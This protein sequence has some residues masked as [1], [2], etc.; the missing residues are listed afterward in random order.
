MGAWQS[1]DGAKAEQ[2]LPLLSAPGMALKTPKMLLH[3]AFQALPH[4]GELYTGVVQDPHGASQA[5]S[6]RATITLPSLLDAPAPLGAELLPG[7]QFAGQGGGKRE[8]EQAAAAAAVDYLVGAVPELTAAR[9]RV[10]P[11]LLAGAVARGQPQPAGRAPS[12]GRTLSSG[13]T[14]SSSRTPSY[15]RAA[16]YSESSGGSTAN[17][18]GATPALSPTRP[19]RLSAPAGGSGAL[20]EPTDAD[21]DSMGTDE[22]RRHLKQALEVIR[23]QREALQAAH[24]HAAAIQQLCL[25]SS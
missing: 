19:A 3:E 1:S 18:F 9:L 8:A 15:R 22:C 16:S 23:G 14:P 21:V 12:Y 20:A 7:R 17:S 11:E 13:G 25:T 10:P 5:P 24:E 6:F 2:P 4:S